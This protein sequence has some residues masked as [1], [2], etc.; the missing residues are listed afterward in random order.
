MKTTEDIDPRTLSIER[1]NRELRSLVE[2]TVH[3]PLESRERLFQALQAAIQLEFSTMPPYLCALWS[4]RDEAHPFA[5]S[6]RKVVQ[7]EMSHMALACNLLVAMGGQP[8]F[9]TA[10]FHPSYPGPLPGGVHPGLVVGLSALTRAQAEAFMVIESPPGA[11]APEGEDHTIGEFYEHILALIRLLNPSFSVDHQVTGPLVPKLIEDVPGAKWAIELIERQGEGS[12]D[13]AS[14][15]GLGRYGGV[16]HYNRFKAIVEGVEYPWDE[17]KRQYVPH[18]LAW[19]E[20]WPMAPVPPGG[21]QPDAVSAEVAA[22]LGAFD[23]AYSQMLGLL[24]MAW[25]PTDAGD[26]PQR[27][28]QAW[29]LAAVEVMFELQQHA[30]A[31]MAIPIPGDPEG[32]T[33]GPC[34]RFR[35]EHAQN[36]ALPLTARS[37]HASR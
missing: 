17:A 32:R 26:R 18:P 1:F 5:R 12:R 11:S 24:E 9:T 7:E 3:T 34:F 30:R 22:L 27:S 15:R 37:H 36:L 19:P 25:R 6:V 4:I 16:S 10:G 8:S 29:L 33:Y 21:Y 14:Y 35:P 23:A 2:A 13:H 31:L 20:V 28:G